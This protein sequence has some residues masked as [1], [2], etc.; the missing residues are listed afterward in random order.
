MAAGKTIT[1]LDCPSHSSSDGR[2]AHLGACVYEKLT[3]GFP[4]KTAID[5][6]PYERFLD[7]LYL[8]STTNLLTPEQIIVINR[9][10][11]RHINS[12]SQFE[13][14]RSVKQLISD[15]CIRL[16]PESVLEIGPGKFPI[17]VDT[18]EY[19][20][21]DIDEEVIDYLGSKG[22]SASTWE[23]LTKSHTSNFDL[24]VACF[25]FHFHVD[26]ASIEFMAKHLAPRGAIVFNVVSK[27]PLIRTNV[28]EK[29]SKYGLS[30][31]AVDLRKRF[32]KTDIL[33]VMHNP[34]FKELHRVL[35]A[36][37]DITN[38]R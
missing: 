16:K 8:P 11:E 13:Y 35:F 33:F 4:P 10:R 31:F 1:K 2:Y 7:S 17:S 15:L 36:P 19:H 27:E 6:R 38:P 9:F 28:F 5:G 30:G 26:E 25:V 12:D 3:G 18:G 20:A 23:V 34:D 22:I 37:P 21:V 14:N 32:G 29:F 24:I